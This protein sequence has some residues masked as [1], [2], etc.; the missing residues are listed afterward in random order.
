MLWQYFLF[1]RLSAGAAGHSV[2]K[3]EKNVAA[4][5]TGEPGRGVPPTCCLG[6]SSLGVGAWER[7]AGDPT[8][9]T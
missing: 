6:G 8:D 4:D 9:R 5:T 2:E 7:Q 3:S 1:F